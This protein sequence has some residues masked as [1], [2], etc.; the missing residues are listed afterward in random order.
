MPKNK[1]TRLHHQHLISERGS[2]G[3]APTN[4]RKIIKY[5]IAV[6]EIDIGNNWPL[7]EGFFVRRTVLNSFETILLKL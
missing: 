2:T 3:T 5:E 7:P 6:V 1:K 4:I